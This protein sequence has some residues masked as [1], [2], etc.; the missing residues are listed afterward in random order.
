MSTMSP[1]VNICSSITSRKLFGHRGEE[2]S[3]VAHCSL[4]SK[5]WSTS[6]KPDCLIQAICTHAS[7]I[8]P[9]AKVEP[10]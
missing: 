9:S 4:Q 3:L 1:T 5:C 10:P 6:I 7:T 8:L 2:E